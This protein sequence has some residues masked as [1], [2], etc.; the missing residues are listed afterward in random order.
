MTELPPELSAIDARPTTAGSG[1]SRALLRGFVAGASPLIAV[2]V[3][4]LVW[5][6]VVRV[7]NVQEFILPPPSLIAA[8]AHRQGSTLVDA[9]RVTL[10]EVLLGFGL[11]VVVGIPLAVLIVY[12]KVIR[13][14]LYP[15]LVAGQAIPRVAIAPL[16]ILWFGLGIQGKVVMAFSVAIFPLII[17]AV[18]GLQSVDRDTMY[19]V[20]SMGAGPLQSFVKVRF[21]AALPSIYGGLKIAVTL[22]VIGA[23]VA[24]FVGSTQG[25]GYLVLVGQATFNTR[26]I[27]ASVAVMALMGI[28]LFYII[29]I[30]ERFTIHWYYAA[31][32]AAE[33]GAPDE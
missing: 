33:E 21:P 9:T 19:V 23:I 1:R 13:S 27:F 18:V 28:V 15:V 2:G 20:Q 12:S 32:A 22:A 26:L 31:R 6:V 17:S 11:C 3:L 29:E 25:L 8:E 14:V 24:E 4:V 7:L 16:M 5:E 10:V 30:V